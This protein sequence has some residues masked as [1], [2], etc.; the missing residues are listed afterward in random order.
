MARTLAVETS[1]GSNQNNSP[2]LVTAGQLSH[3]RMIESAHRLAI[4]TERGSVR[5]AGV[6]C[7]LVSQADYVGLAVVIPRPEIVQIAV[8]DREPATVNGEISRQILGP[9]CCEW[10]GI[11]QSIFNRTFQ[12]VVF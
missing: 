5:R 10:C 12:R 2:N 7:S 4:N 1:M 11:V 6:L 3:G 8:N 9:F